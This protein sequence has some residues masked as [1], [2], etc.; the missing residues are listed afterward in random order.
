MNDISLYA[1]LYEEIRELADLV[2]EVI[3]IL[4]ED[5]SAKSDYT[6]QLGRKLVSLGTNDTEGVTQLFIKQAIQRKS[7]LTKSKIQ[8]L[9]SRLI[10]KKV[11][12]DTIT[13]LEKLAISIE[14]ERVT[15]MSRMRGKKI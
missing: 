11:T 2:D 12:S 13:D 9:G 5:S 1:G 10:E 4:K 3:I 15:V 8:Q 7:G 6:E 14:Q